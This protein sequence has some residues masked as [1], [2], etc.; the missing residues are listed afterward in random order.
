M[1]ENTQYKNDLIFS[2]NTKT[3]FMKAKP[4][5]NIE[6]V[7]FSFVSFDEAAEAG[8]KIKDNVDFYMSIDD[9]LYLSWLITEGHLTKMI[10]KEAAK[11]EKY[12]KAVYTRQGG[13]QAD[14]CKEKGIRTD[15]AALARV[16]SITPGSKQPYVFKIEQGPEE[17]HRKDLSFQ[18][19][20]VRLR[21]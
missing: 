13:I 16:L 7:L 12:P 8:S 6:K 20:R 4:C 19:G 18:L 10:K 3:T 2:I 9:A 11:G 15:D 1:A 21:L 5:F 14:K 17:K